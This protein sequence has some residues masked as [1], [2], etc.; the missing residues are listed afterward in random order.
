MIYDDDDDDDDD[1]D[2]DDDDADGDDELESGTILSCKTFQVYSFPTELEQWYTVKC[3]V[4]AVQ[5]ITLLHTA[6]R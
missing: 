5:F 2:N 1:D 3:R 4:N 6:L